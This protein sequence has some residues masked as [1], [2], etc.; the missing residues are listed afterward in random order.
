MV[1]FDTLLNIFLLR[2]TTEIVDDVYTDA[3]WSKRSEQHEHS[4]CSTGYSDHSRNG[5]QARGETA[6]RSSAA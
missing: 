5:A 2:I 6:A 1:V 4:H 3:A